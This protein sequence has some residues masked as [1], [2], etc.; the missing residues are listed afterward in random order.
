M[1]LDQVQFSLLLP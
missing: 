1:R